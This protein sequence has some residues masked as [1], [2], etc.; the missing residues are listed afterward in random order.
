MRLRTPWTRKEGASM[1]SVEGALAGDR[2]P[3]GKIELPSEEVLWL[4]TEPGG[5]CELP[6]WEVLWLNTA[7]L[8]RT[9]GDDSDL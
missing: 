4:M 3:G 1:P 5:V 9:G 2:E 8:A 6:S 7:S